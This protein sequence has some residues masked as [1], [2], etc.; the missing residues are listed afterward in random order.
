MKYPTLLQTITELLECHELSILHDMLAGADTADIARAAAKLKNEDLL[1]VFRIMSKDTSA[2]VFSHLKTADQT[3]LVESITDRELERL[4]EEMDT[5]GT[6]DFI[7]EAPAIL[8][9]RALARSDN[10]ETREVIN[11]FL[12]YRENSAG[13][14][15][16]IE[17]VELHD[18]VTA[19]EAVDSIRQTGYNKETVYTCY[20]I[21]ASRHLIGSVD[22][23]DL[24]FCDADTRVGDIISEKEPLISVTT[25]DD[26]GYVAALARKHDLLSVP[27]VDHENRLV[28]IITIDDIMD[29]MQEKATEDIERMNLLTPSG[30]EYLKT[31]VWRLAWNRLPLLLILMLLATVTEFIISE[32]EHK[33]SLIAGLIACIPMLMDTGGNAG[34]Q[35]SALVIRGLSVGE[36][37]LADFFRVLF[38]ELRVSLICGLALAVT[39]F[40]RMLL[41]QLVEGGVPGTPVIFVVSAALLAAII[42]AKTIGCTLPMLA[43]L[44]HID[45]ARM[46]GPVIATVVDAVALLIY[47]ALAERF[48]AFV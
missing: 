29:V 3:R 35:A 33:L 25:D 34:H 6:A 14:I 13:S 36:V 21:D 47:F 22:L 39:N 28:G 44:A 48:L 12:R 11:H 32:A 19:Q 43:K 9:K 27:V 45:P 41:M 40:L 24:L 30:T 26:R 15:M 37:K 10:N 18:R 8:V 7:E 46:S 16:T 1:R 4:L 38:K 31:G 17:M 2:E 5:D 42:V 20:C 23:H